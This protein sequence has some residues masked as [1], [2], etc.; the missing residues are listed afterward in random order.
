MTVT[1]VT[2]QHNKINSASSKVMILGVGVI[3]MMTV[4]GLGE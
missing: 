4:D 3:Q 2:L 1:A